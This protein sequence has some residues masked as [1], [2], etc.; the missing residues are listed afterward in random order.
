MKVSPLIISFSIISV[1]MINLDDI[2]IIIKIVITI[3]IAIIGTITIIGI[4]IIIQ[5]SGVGVA[6][7]MAC[8][9]RLE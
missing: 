4:I 7:T 5:L 9:G 6:K 1:T 2:I 3:T 8:T